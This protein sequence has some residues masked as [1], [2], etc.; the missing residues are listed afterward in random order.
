M[1]LAG[2]ERLRRSPTAEP[3]VMEN[4]ANETCELLGIIILCLTLC[5]LSQVTANCAGQ[6]C[7]G[8]HPIQYHVYV[9]ICIYIFFFF[10]IVPL[11]SLRKRRNGIM[12]FHALFSPS[13]SQWKL[14]LNT[15]VQHRLQRDTA[16]PEA[17]T[18]FMHNTSDAK[19]ICQLRTSK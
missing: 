18:V 14:H 8:T 17:C 19:R 6:P 9:Y 1:T 5:E 16:W 3:H 12:N 15:L 10:F 7:T 4:V 11:N 13:S 2:T